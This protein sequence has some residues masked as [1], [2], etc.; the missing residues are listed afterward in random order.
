[1]S[2]PKILA[3]VLAGGEG[4]RLHPLTA[5]RS[6]PA[7][8]FRGRYRIVDFVL[9][10]L[11]NSGI[12]SIYLLVQYKA[13]SLIEHL[14]KSWM[15]SSVVPGQFIT[16]VPPQM[17]DGQ[18]WFKGTA[19][20]VFQNRNLIE[21]HAPDMVA[22]FGA[23]HVYRMD[24]S[25]MLDFHLARSADI[26]LAA[27][28]V[29]VGQASAFGIIAVDPDGRVIEF[30]EKPDRPREMPGRPGYVLASMGNYLF[31]TRVLKRALREVQHRGETDFGRHLL[32]RLLRD[33]RLYAYDF[34]SNRIPGVK[35]YEEQAYWRDVGTIAA[36]FD[37]SMDVLGPEPRFDLF[38]PQWPIHSSYYDGPV[39][40]VMS[41]AI[42]NSV[43]AGGAVIKGGTIVNSILRREVFVEPDA[44]L[45]DCIILDNVTIQR[46]CRLRRVIVDS[47]NSLP[48]GTQ[49]G[50]DPAADQAHYHVDP[51]GIVVVPQGRSLWDT[52]SYFE[53][54]L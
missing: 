46:G 17:R 24:V 35:L 22:V 38:N 12:Q 11:V 34:M 1:M 45:E 52:D 41:G 13:Q 2:Q 28:P 16:V 54:E 43:I 23:D 19:D 8:P 15:H 21:L 37:S 39:A 40:K 36:Y 25:Q 4:S 50:L 20:A 49:V 51:S 9:S 29:P 18:E 7:V 53:G 47:T 44:E 5:E 33:H 14:R 32:P 27:I 26:S 30:Q 10:N 48:P 42:R 3:L 6:K 31:N